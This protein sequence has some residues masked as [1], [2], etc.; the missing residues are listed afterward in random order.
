MD[1]EQFCRKIPKLELHVHLG[2]SVRRSTIEESLREQK[3]QDAE[4]FSHSC[5]IKGIDKSPM[6]VQMTRFDRVGQAWRSWAD[7]RR[8]VLEFIEDCI[9][10]NVIYVEM[11][12]SGSSKEKLETI[13]QTFHEHK[14]KNQ[15]PIMKLVV[16]INRTWTIEQAE[17]ALNLAIE[18]KKEN[19]DIVGLDFCDNPRKGTFQQFTE[20]FKKG[21]ENGFFFTSHFA[22]TDEE[23]DLDNI[24]NSNPGNF[25]SLFDSFLL[26]FFFF[27]AKFSFLV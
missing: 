4:E 9:K 17:K 7:T 3:R 18:L 23:K 8:Y 11:R 15:F 14:Q 10:D 22:E 21:K 13:L 26:F 12:T 27:S 16:S 1:A 20:I 19:N 2:G 25:F 5:V 6:D 24:L